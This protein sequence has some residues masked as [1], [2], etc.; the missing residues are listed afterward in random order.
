MRAIVEDSKP[1]IENAARWFYSGKH[2]AKRTIEQDRANAEKEFARLMRAQAFEDERAAVLF[3]RMGETRQSIWKIKYEARIAEARRLQE[4]VDA[5]AR[6][7]REDSKL[8]D[9][10]FERAKRRARL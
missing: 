3:Q 1:A 2:S 10:V 7:V 5:Q 8:A 9:A 6:A 4:V